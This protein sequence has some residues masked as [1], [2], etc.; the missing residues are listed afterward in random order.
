MLKGILN[1]IMS[2]RPAWTTGKREIERDRVGG[3]DYRDRHGEIKGGGEIPPNHSSP[4]IISKTMS[5]H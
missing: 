5:S 2:L 4:M 1:Y 3:R